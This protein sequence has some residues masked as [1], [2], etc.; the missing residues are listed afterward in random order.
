MAMWVEEFSGEKIEQLIDAALT[1]PYEE[2]LHRVQGRDGDSNGQI[3]GV[4][5][6]GLEH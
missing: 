2:L 1:G 3:G 4:I 5:M 6:T